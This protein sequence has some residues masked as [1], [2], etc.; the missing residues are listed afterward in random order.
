VTFQF[1]VID[2]GRV[3]SA[4]AT[5]TIPIRPIATDHPY[6]ASPSQQLSVDAGSGL[7]TGATGPPGLIVDTTS[8]NAQNFDAS[9][10][11]LT[12]NPDGSFTITP[13]DSEASS[14]L[15]FTYSVQ[16]SDGVDSAPATV[17]IN[18]G[19]A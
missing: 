14:T 13:Q 2:S 19:P 12:V 18:V 1:T 5:V 16:N 4:P 10:D 3:V 15:T 7:L 8:V 6:A 11:G 9:T 17:T